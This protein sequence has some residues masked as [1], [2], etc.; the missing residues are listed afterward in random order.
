MNKVILMGRLT[1][2][3][4]IRYSQGRVQLRSQDFHLQLIVA[5]VVIMRSRQRISLTVLPLAEQQNFWRDSV[6]REQ[7]LFLKAVY[8]QVATQ[9]RM[10]SVFTQQTLSQRMLSLQRAR[11]TAQQAMT[12]A[13]HQVL[14][15]QAELPEMVL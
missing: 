1:R 15:H 7:S 2:D 5:S 9:T 14:H 8:R 6:V 13:V 12:L 11:T 3:A 10:D 4:E